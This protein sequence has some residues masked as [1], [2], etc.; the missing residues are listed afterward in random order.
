MCQELER[1]VNTLRVDFL[2]SGGSARESPKKL[3]NVL[4]LLVKDDSRRLWEA[5]V[6]D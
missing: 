6:G 1:K 4:S 2:S 3:K 5:D